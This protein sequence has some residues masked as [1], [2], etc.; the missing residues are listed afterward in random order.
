[1]RHVLLRIVGIVL[2]VGPG[3][4]ESKK[5]ASHGDPSREV[6]ETILF[7]IAMWTEHNGRA[8]VAGLVAATGLRMVE[9]LRQNGLNWTAA[10][11]YAVQDANAGNTRGTETW[12]GFANVATVVLDS[13]LAEFIQPEPG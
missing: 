2:G 8:I 12:L 6:F 5:K 10:T 13:Q 4:S 7:F 3:R 9:G 11:A 1:M